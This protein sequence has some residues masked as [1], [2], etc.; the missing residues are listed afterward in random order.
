M[1]PF[2]EGWTTIWKD[3]TTTFFKAEG[4][5]LGLAGNLASAW[6]IAL[7]IREKGVS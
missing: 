3:K 6:E 1:K 7:A 4:G 2:L 5:E